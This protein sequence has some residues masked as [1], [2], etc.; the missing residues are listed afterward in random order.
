MNREKFAELMEYSPKTIWP[1]IS[2]QIKDLN[3]AILRKYGAND[4][5]TL[6]FEESAE[7]TKE[8]CKFIRDDKKKDMYGI[9]EELTDLT[10]VLDRLE[11]WISWTL[12]GVTDRDYGDIMARAMEIKL[13]EL[14]KKHIV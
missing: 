12:E 14:K 13:E 3:K 6:F 10:I 9:I 5:F 1:V 2:E 7:L 11:E 4:C 8:L